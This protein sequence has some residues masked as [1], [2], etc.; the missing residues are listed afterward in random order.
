MEVYR[1]C[2]MP[3]FVKLRRGRKTSRIDSGWRLYLWC[4]YALNKIVTRKVAIQTMDG[5]AAA[6]ISQRSG[7]KLIADC[8]TTGIFGVNN[9]LNL[10]F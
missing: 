3:L 2:Q 7:P 8:R 4:L 9:C 1:L 5:P 6:L 10:L